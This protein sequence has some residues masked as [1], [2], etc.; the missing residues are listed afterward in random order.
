M[1]DGDRSRQNMKIL[2]FSDSHEDIEPMVNVV[3]ALSPDMIIHLGDH[4]SDAVE[5]EQRFMKISFEY[6]SGNCDLNSF[7]PSSKTL[8]IKN[9]TIFISHGD[10]Y[11]VRSG[12]SGIVKEGKKRRA[13]IILFGHTHQPVV[14]NKHG[15]ILMNPG[16]IGRHARGFW[17]PSF[18]IVEITDKVT[19]NT[20]DYEFYMKNLL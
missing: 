1:K 5:L 9:K 16:R 11:G 17:Q 14:K 6:V 18:G 7:V 4:V 12:T 13:D 20:L 19:C 15:I 10:E 8:N 2:V 3:R